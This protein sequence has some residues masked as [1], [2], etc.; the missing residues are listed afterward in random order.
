M[1]ISRSSKSHIQWWI[2]N[3]EVSFKLI[4]HGKPNREIYTD[5]SKTGW[6]RMTKL[7]TSV[8][9]DIGQRRTGRPHFRTEGNV[10][11]AESF[12]WFRVQYTHSI[13]L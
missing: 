8:Q 3:L 11:G 10:L 13:I 5:S 12:M 1:I 7:K 4:S 6:G 9:V 2:D